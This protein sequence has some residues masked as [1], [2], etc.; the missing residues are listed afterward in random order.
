MSLTSCGKSDGGTESGE[1]KS[2]L[3]G[4]FTYQ[5]TIGS[6]G[7]LHITNDANKEAGRRYIYSTQYPIASGNEGTPVAYN[8]DQRLKLNRD[9]TYKYDYTILLSNPRDWGAQFAR[10]TFGITGTFTYASFD[11]GKY[12]V[13]LSDPTAGT[14]AVFA[15]HISGQDNYSWSMHSQPDYV[16]DYEVMNTVEG[17]VCDKYA[18]SRIVAVDKGS[19]RLRD[20]IYYAD[21]LDYITAYSTY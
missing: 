17:Y 15:S 6:D 4:T 20:D 11:D 3:F 21:I 14:Q 8:M 13:L 7:S 1:K 12:S 16:V 2:E 18:K 5:E 9:F 19:K 10:V